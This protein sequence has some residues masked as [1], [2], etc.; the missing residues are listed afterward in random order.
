MSSPLHTPESLNAWAKGSFVELLDIRIVEVAQRRLTAEMEV[1]SELI[2]PNGYLHAGSIVALADTAAGFGCRANLP[3][4]GS[5]FTTI[6]LKSNFLGTATEG[7]LTCEAVLV[8]GGRTTQVWDATVTARATGKTIALFRCT[9]LVLYP[10]TEGQSE[11][12][13]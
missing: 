8:H 11:D 9:Q 12:K 5:G 1:R 3:A 2:A 10:R 4:G 6:E 7:M 13:R